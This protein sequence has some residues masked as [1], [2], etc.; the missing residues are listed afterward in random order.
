MSRPGSHADACIRTSSPR[1]G[2]PAIILSRAFWSKSF[3][4]EKLLV[5]RSPGVNFKTDGRKYMICSH[6][7]KKPAALYIAAPVTLAVLGR[8]GW[9]TP[10]ALNMYFPFPG[11]FTRHP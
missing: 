4:S 10:P 9:S 7:V 8:L 2:V 6:D 1:L 11:M 3:S 5:Y